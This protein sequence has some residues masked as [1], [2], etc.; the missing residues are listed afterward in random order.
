MNKNNEIKKLPSFEVDHLLLEPGVYLSREKLVGNEI[1]RTFDVRIYKPHTED[2]I[3]LEQMHTT[4]HFLATYFEHKHAE[5][6]VYIGPMG[7]QT[8][9]YIV[10]KGN[11]NVN[12]IMDELI[13]FYKTVILNANESNIPGNSLIEC[14]NPRTLKSDVTKDMW[15]KYYHLYLNNK[16]QFTYPK[17]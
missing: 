15:D 3:S 10:V 11:W 12:R 17:R 9:F 7:C 16:L 1:I 8:G 5:D 4:E 14:G 2:L 13:N 6:K